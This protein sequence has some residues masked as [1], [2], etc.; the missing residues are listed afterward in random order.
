MLPELHYLVWFISSMAPGAPIIFR[1]RRSDITHEPSTALCADYDP[2]ALH[3]I[4]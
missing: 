3:D 4:A 1:R 2:C